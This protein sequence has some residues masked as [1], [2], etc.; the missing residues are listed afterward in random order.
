MTQPVGGETKAAGLGRSWS[1]RDK[2]GAVLVWSVASNAFVP[3]FV[4]SP[5]LARIG[6]QSFL[7]HGT[8]CGDTVSSRLLLITSHSAGHILPA[9]SSSCLTGRPHHN[10]ARRARSCKVTRCIVQPS[11]LAAPPKTLILIEFPHTSKVCK[12]LQFLCQPSPHVEAWTA[13]TPDVR[14]G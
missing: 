14:L 4:Q 11:Q 7:H 9:G 6:R 10:S 13:G 3:R 1:P 2:A 12:C 5:R 8:S